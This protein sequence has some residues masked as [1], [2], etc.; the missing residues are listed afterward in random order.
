M[1]AR[2]K[3]RKSSAWVCDCGCRFWPNRFHLRNL[4]RLS[5]FL[6]ALFL[7]ENDV[8]DL[9]ALIKSEKLAELMAG[10]KLGGK[11]REEFSGEYSIIC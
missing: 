5:C 10:R 4:A 2:L 11:L 7:L 6:L 3:W 9:R 8:R 1:C